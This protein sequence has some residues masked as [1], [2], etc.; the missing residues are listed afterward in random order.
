MTSGHSAGCSHFRSGDSC[1][2]R[3]NSYSTGSIAPSR[4]PSRMSRAFVSSSANTPTGG[5][6]LWVV[7]NARND[8][9][10]GSMPP[11]ICRS[12]LG[13]LAIFAQT[14]SSSI[15]APPLIF[16]PVSTDGS[17]V[18]ISSSAFVSRCRIV[19]RWCRTWNLRDST[20]SRSIAPAAASNASCATSCTGAVMTNDARGRWFISSAVTISSAPSVVLLFFF[21]TRA[22]SSR[23][24]R[25]RVAGST[26]P[27]M[28]RTMS[29]NHSPPA[30][31]IVGVPGTSAR[32]SL[33]KIRT[34][35]SPSA[36]HSGRSGTSDFPCWRRR[37]Q[38]GHDRSQDISPPGAAASHPAA[39]VQPSPSPARP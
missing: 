21:G 34:A 33:L 1:T 20:P 29:R 17:K 11:R 19:F 14:C 26:D 28:A 12:A 36:V 15:S 32:R 6:S 23:I 30:S 24:I 39:A 9:G 35:R 16:C 4:L 31:S 7:M 18:M 5:S 13:A 25:C 27:N 8:S 2:S 3:G 38:S 22:N 10:N 37:H